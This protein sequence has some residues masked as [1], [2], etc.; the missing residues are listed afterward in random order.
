MPP[1]MCADLCMRCSYS[2][3]YS[4]FQLPSNSNNDEGWLSASM[5]ITFHSQCVYAL[6]LRIYTMIWYDPT[7]PLLLL[8]CMY[9]FS[10]WSITKQ[11]KTKGKWRRKGEQSCSGE[12]V[13]VAVAMM[14]VKGKEPWRRPCQLWQWDFLQKNW[15]PRVD[16]VGGLEKN[17]RQTLRHP[18]QSPTVLNSREREERERVKEEGIIQKGRRESTT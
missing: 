8:L 5:H 2:F 14:K 10:C 16:I 4:N 17:H 12:G 1:W 3:H 7:T 11:G 13:S 9:F 6:A 18:F 15:N